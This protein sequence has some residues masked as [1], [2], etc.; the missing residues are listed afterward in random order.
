M[1][2]SPVLSPTLTCKH[3]KAAMWTVGCHRFK[4]CLCS[5][6]TSGKANVFYLHTCRRYIPQHDNDRV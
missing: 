5:F 1:D 3:V 2:H 4:C 6:A